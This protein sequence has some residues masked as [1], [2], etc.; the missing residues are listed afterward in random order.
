MLNLCLKYISD[1]NL[2]RKITLMHLD[3]EAQYGATTDYVRLMEEK[4]V[5]CLDVWHICVPFKVTT[6]T[7]MFQS[8]WRPWEESKKGI[9]VREMPDNAMTIESCPALNEATQ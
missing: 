9:W 6:C 3:Y 2:D 7:S 5:D 8:F 4:Y 1:N